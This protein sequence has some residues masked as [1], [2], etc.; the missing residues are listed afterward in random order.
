MAEEFSERRMQG[1][2]FHQVDLRDAEFDRVTFEG[3]SFRSVDLRGATVRNAVFD[4]TTIRGE[5]KS[6]HLHGEV[7]SLTVNGV[8]VAHLVDAELDRLHPE[9][10]KL[11]PTDPAGYRE[12]WRIIEDLWSGTVD[13]ARALP[14]EMLHESVN[15]EWS[16][17][18]TLRHLLFAT[19][20]WIRRVILGDP[21]PWHPLDL[22]WDEMPDTPA[23][24]RDRAARPS[25]DEV[26][27]LR[28]D[29]MASMRQVLDD[30]TDEQL[31]GTTEPV[32]G[33]GWPPA[34]GFPVKLILDT[35]INEEWWHRQFAERDLA[36]LV[37]R[38]RP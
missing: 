8:E 23:I 30:L 16:F 5:F 27:D 9:R 17:I 34:V 37:E 24:P 26:L 7:V 14:S 13:G 28:R 29:R 31:A 1:A 35:I 11:R 38:T 33:P 12:A 3:A 36:V 32:E 22:P 4:D 19:D 21:S 6:L 15:G 18:E 20:A 25:L 2:R 10:P